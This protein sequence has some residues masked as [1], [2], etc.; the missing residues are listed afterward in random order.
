MCEDQFRVLVRDNGK[1]MYTIHTIYTAPSLRGR[2]VGPI[3][4]TLM[5]PLTALVR[6]AGKVDRRASSPVKGEG[7]VPVAQIVF[8]ISLPLIVGSWPR[9]KPGRHCCTP[10]DPPLG[11]WPTGQGRSQLSSAGLDLQQ[12][13]SPGLNVSM[14]LPWPATPRLTVDLLRCGPLLA[15][16][17][18]QCARR[19]ARRAQ[20]PVGLPNP[21]ARA[22]NIPAQSSAAHDVAAAWSL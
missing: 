16:S 14:S 7:G 21:Q 6:S 5:L 20:L 13:S 18:C 12:T 10:R 2:G 4:V 1:L 15:G 8:I 11:P 19:Q 3:S 17:S 9:A 22:A